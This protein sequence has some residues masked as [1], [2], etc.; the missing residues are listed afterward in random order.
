MAV[1]KKKEPAKR[2][3]RRKQATKTRGTLTTV[4]S[5]KETGEKEVETS[6][7]LAV[8]DDTERQLITSGGSALALMEVQLRLART[9]QNAVWTDMRDK[10]ELPPEFTWDPATGEIFPES[11]N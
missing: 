9:G 7:V 6:T 8:L 3:P 2:T 5:S 10:Y 4:K 11:D 1:A